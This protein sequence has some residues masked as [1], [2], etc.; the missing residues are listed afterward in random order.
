MPRHHCYPVE[1]GMRECA[2]RC[3][4]TPDLRLS[5]R[6]RRA[7]Y[8]RCNGRS[9]EAA[10][11]ATRAAATLGRPPQVLELAKR[12]NAVIKVTGGRTLS[13]EP[14]RFPDTG[15]PRSRVR[16]LGFRPLP[17]GRR[18]D[19]RVRCCQHDQAV[20]PFL[21]AD[22]LSDTKR[23]TSASIRAAISARNLGGRPLR[24]RRRRGQSRCGW[25]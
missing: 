5:R 1:V 9:P 8:R 13:R 10:E 6:D 11:R 4:T 25:R 24:A 12:K 14:Y 21:K 3:A 2:D 22:R 16:R 19:A 23:A 18:L 7:R 17:V 15:A 20:E